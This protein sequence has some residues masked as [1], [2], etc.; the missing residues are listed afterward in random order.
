MTNLG[1]PRIGLSST[2]LGD[3][4]FIFTWNNLH[5]LIIFW[6][7]IW[8]FRLHLSARGR[9]VN[10]AS[11]V[12]V[13]RR[14]FPVIQRQIQRLGWRWKKAQLLVSNVT[15]PRESPFS[16]SLRTHKR[17]K[18]FSL[19]R[20]RKALDMRKEIFRKSHIYHQIQRLQR[21]TQV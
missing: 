8:V 17:V 11:V 12:H 16:L 20:G 2:L 3:R 10:Q 14:S 19:Q 5:D 9:F 1:G 6:I 7:F 4:V 13:V 21:T 18:S 15:A